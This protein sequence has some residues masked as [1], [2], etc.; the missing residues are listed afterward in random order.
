M[1]P[2][3]VHWVYYDL[4][5]ALRFWKR[6]GRGVRP[7]YVLWQ[8]GALRLARRLHRRVRF[9]LAHHATFVNYWL[10][11]FVPFLEIPYIWGPVAGAESAPRP[12][13]RTFSFRGRLYELGRDLVRAA[14]FRSPL[15]RRTARQSRL[16]IAATPETAAR[17]GALG[18]PRVMLMSQVGLTAA[19][20]ARLGG[21]PAPPRHRQ[22][23]FFSVGTLSHLKGLHLSLSAFSAHLRT[24]PGSEYWIVGTGPEEG[25]L[26]RLAAR[27]GITSRV[28]FLGSMLRARVWSLLE[29]CDVLVHAGLH[30]SGG[31]ACVEA[32]AAGRPVICFDLGGPGHL[33]DGECGI[34]IRA[35][36]PDAAIRAFAA[37]MDTMTDAALRRRLGRAA[38][39]R[40]EQRFTWEKKG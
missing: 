19:D 15:V 20:R 29:E 23:R 22:L 39:E 31:Y 27:L 13:Y 36:S 9:D 16:A 18:A 26:R 25:R 34:T 37:A 7:Y 38:R 11:T 6:G 10:P 32:M 1:A 2:P 14:G 21:V 3:R 12:F 5:P 28:R 30:D 17:L 33:I 40:V 8:F 24:F 35:V 4:P